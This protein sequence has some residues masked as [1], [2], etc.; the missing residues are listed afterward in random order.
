MLKN[1]NHTQTFKILYLGIV[2]CKYRLL[3]I[4]PFVQVYFQNILCLFNGRFLIF[5]RMLDKTDIHWSSEVGHE[6]NI[7]QIISKNCKNKV[8]LEKNKN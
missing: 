8:L 2:K 1:H 4:F 3:S 7:K 6:L 5:L